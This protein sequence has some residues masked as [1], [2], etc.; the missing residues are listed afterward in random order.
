MVT[1]M[2]WII[3]STTSVGSVLA[4]Q[5]VTVQEAGGTQSWTIVITGNTVARKTAATAMVFDRS[6]SMSED[7]GDGQSKHDSLQQAA[8]I[9]VDLMLAGDGVGI[10]A[11]NDNAQV[12]QS[13]LQLGD[14]GLTDFNRG[15]TK[16]IINGTGLNPSGSTSIGD[17]IFDG[18]GILTAAASSFDVNAMVVLTDGMENSP[19]YIADV[20]SLINA[21]T[22]AVGLG[23]PQNISVPALQEISGNNGGYLLVTGA[24]STNNRFE[25]TK[26]FVQI[27]AGISNAEIV[28]DP[29]G[30]LTSGHLEKVPF[31]LTAADSGVD[32]ILLTPNTKIIDFRLL[33]P[34]GQIIEPWLAMSEPGM[35]FVLS[36]GVSYYRLALPYEFMP[37]RFD[38]GGTWYALLRIGGPRLEPGN[39]ANGVDY[40]IMNPVP[41]VQATASAGR[42][43]RLQHDSIVAAEERA[44]CPVVS[45]NAQASANNQCIVPYS[46]VVHAYSNISLAA[47]TI[48]TSFEPGASIQLDASLFQSG[49]PG[50]TQGYIWAEVTRPNGTMVNVP[51]AVNET[52]DFVANYNTSS[53]GVYRFRIRAIGTSA[54]GERF[55]REK[56][57]TAAVWQ[58]GNYVVNP[59]GGHNNTQKYLCELLQCLLRRNGAITPDL[60]KRLEALGF[61]LAQAR[62]CFA[63]L[64]STASM[65]NR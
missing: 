15:A 32:V 57:L 11:F 63:R 12:L 44:K 24:I 64:C 53:P 20:A 27:L 8:G 43:L 51:M 14:G 7:A 4:P 54:N 30:Q 19:K 23:Q 21:N 16:D 38:A 22:Y 62:E 46:I 55:T 65:D 5:T 2:L 31:Q 29:T 17:G 58:G 28:L 56:T 1:A 61:N 39:T 48:Q 3:Y 18:S 25:L 10:V 13:V 33:T 40:S 9:F 52:G 37:N 26:Y 35:R 45:T 47:H 59:S 41:K 42:G 36:N 49:I 34:S 50:I 60:E 6:G